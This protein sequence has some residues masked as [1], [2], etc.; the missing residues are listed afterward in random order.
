MLDE[1]EKGQD[2]EGKLRQ[3]KKEKKKEKKKIMAR[4]STLTRR[5]SCSWYARIRLRRGFGWGSCGWSVPLPTIW[6]DIL[7]LRLVH[8]IREVK[9]L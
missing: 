3:K 9:T 6:R 7:T 1:H 2:E 4:T 8:L 5:G